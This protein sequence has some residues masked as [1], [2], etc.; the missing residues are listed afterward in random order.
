MT[1]M[2][3]NADGAARAAGGQARPRESIIRENSGRNTHMVRIITPTAVGALL[4]GALALASPAHAA[5]GPI[6]F[7][8]GM[9][10]TGG[11]A[12]NGKAAVFAIQTWAS[13]VNARGGL[14]GRKVELIHYD[15]QSNPSLVPGIYTK[16]L[17]IDKVDL[18]CSG[19]GTNQTAPAM[20][21]VMQHNMLFLSNFALAV[22]DE[23]HYDKYFQ[24]QPNGPAARLEF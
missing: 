21:I 2:L 7:G 18:V 6:K 19:Y 5:D 15:D 24:I 13:D 9:A 23:F 1:P 17:D 20:P 22:N 14:L 16:L 12:G 4:M 3:D 11:L 10:Q 8:F